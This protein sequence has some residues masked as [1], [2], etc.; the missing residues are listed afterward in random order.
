MPVADVIARQLENASWIRRMF[1]EGIRLK[2]ERGADNVQDFTLGNPVLEP[3]AA[4]QDALRRFAGDPPAGS[5]AY[6]PNAGYEHVRE[7]VAGSL[8]AST[9]LPFEAADVLMTVGS[10][11]AIN[12]CLK[13]ILDPG[14]EVILLM[15]CFSEYP[16][17]VQNHGGRVVAVETGE[18]FLPDP[19]RIAAAITP[20]TKAIIL[21]TPNNPTGRIYPAETLAEMEKVLARADQVIVISDEPYKQLVFDGR[22]QPE[23]ASFITRTAIAYSWSKAFAVPGERI[24]YLALSP[25]LAERRAL[26]GACAFANRILGFINAPALW[27]WAIGEAIDAPVDV[28]PYRDNRN[29]LCEILTRIGY[30]APRPEGTFYVFAR[31]PM[32]DDIAFVRLLQEHGVLAA[33]G[34]GFGRPGYIRFSLTVSRRTI[35]RAAPA[36]ERAFESCV[37]AVS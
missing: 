28:A 23:P 26:R 1:E 4:V 33:P 29:L 27:Q 20:R 22:R 13:A 21:N 32:P 17:Y 30:D 12:V 9:G 6:M 15:P 8:R 35:E 2:A 11:G 25:G 34:A 36:L 7:R 24:G 31:T 37:S 16:F 5:H 3:P 10:S 18:D 19:G 14:D